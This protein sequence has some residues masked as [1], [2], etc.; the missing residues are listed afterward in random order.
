M[1]RFTRYG[2]SSDIFNAALDRPFAGNLLFHTATG[3]GI[4]YADGSTANF[5]GTGL[6]WSDS[7][8]RFTAGT[9]TAIRHYIDGVVNDT[10]LDLSVSAAS[11]EQ[12]FET[13]SSAESLRIFLYS[14]NDVLDGGHQ[15]DNPFSAV[16]LIGYNGDDTIYGSK[17]NDLLGGEN[18]ND[19][20]T[21]GGGDDKIYGGS[22][23]DVIYG[24]ANTDR[25]N[26]GSGNDILNGDGGDDIL[27]GA[28]GNDIYFGGKGTDTAVYAR[29]LYDL[30]ITVTQACLKVIEPH[31]VDTLT[32]IERIAADEGVFVYNTS[33]H[34]W[35]QISDT[36][37]DLL[38]NPGSATEGS[39]AAETIDLADTGNNIA[40]GFG[41]NDLIIGTGDFDLLL[42]GD[43]NDTI[44]GEANQKTGNMD[45]LHGEAGNDKLYGYAGDDMLYGG[46]G[47]DL[48]SGGNGDDVMTGGAG[49]DVFVF[50]W[51]M[52]A[53]APEDWADDEINDFVIGIDHLHLN[54]INIPD[55]TNLT[56]SLVQTAQG[57]LIE[58]GGVGTILLKDVDA[59]G[60]TLADFLV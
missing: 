46:D 22:G 58:L 40:R 60:H 55:G 2:T 30:L 3:F 5:T 4:A 29:S 33:S 41:G 54:F 24:G 57:A 50:N 48:L 16:K 15:R 8:G 59:T 45:R 56:P 12:Q 18:G 53:N 13:A 52:S 37:G 7:L 23:A 25:V 11:L 9:V 34:K 21:G 47:G 26:A 43:G 35:D 32:S 20:I 14:G 42:G 38:L 36:P 6:V 39:D 51:R 31:G 17:G 28:A 49:A 1:A 44:K 10:L 19:T 27:H